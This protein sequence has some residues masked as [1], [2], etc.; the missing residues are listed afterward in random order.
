ML[1]SIRKALARRAL[2]RKIDGAIAAQIILNPDK[3]EYVAGTTFMYFTNGKEDKNE[4]IRLQKNSGKWAVGGELA[5]KKVS[6]VMECKLRG[7]ILVEEEGARVGAWKEVTK[8]FKVSF[9]EINK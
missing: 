3:L 8:F 9:E 5:G 4:W 2:E 1:S 7:L 6:K